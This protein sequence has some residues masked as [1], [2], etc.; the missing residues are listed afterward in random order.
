MQFATYFYALHLRQTIKLPV[1]FDESHELRSLAASARFS[2]FG[3]PKIG[4]FSFKVAEQP[5]VLAEEKGFEPLRAINSGGFQDRCHKPLGHSSV[6]FT[7]NNTG[8]G[9]GI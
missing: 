4:H 7:Y 3:R 8:A 9:D 6:V 5:I 1:T 2:S